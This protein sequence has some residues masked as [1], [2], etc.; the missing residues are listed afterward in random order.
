MLRSIYGIYEHIQYSVDYTGVKLEGEK[1][2]KITIQMF[3]KLG[4]R[5]KRR[6]L[7]LIFFYYLGLL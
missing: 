2:G 4:L 1:N 5:G 3:M 7:L 6:T